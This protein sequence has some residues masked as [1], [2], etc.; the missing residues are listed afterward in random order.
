MW[1]DDFDMDLPKIIPS[2]RALFE[3][4][5]DVTV[6][7]HGH[8][9]HGALNHPT[10]WNHR[11]GMVSFF[12]FKDPQKPVHFSTND[13]IVT[14]TVWEAIRDLWCHSC[15]MI[16]EGQ[17]VL[18]SFEMQADFHRL[19]ADRRGW[20]PLRENERRA[21]IAFC[22]TRLMVTAHWIEIIWRRFV[23]DHEQARC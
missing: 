13:P 12:G 2:A 19:M 9:T 14:C 20:T 4:I 23:R 21:T 1:C 7:T 10:V 3:D 18:N 11:L 22:E 16:L 17:P 15:T 8:E 6:M 5:A